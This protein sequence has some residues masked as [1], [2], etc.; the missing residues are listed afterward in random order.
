M[1]SSKNERFKPIVK[2]PKVYT[3]QTITSKNS[4]SNKSIIEDN[5]TNLYE[6]FMS[7]LQ[8]RVK[9][10]QSENRVKEVYLKYTKKRS[11]RDNLDVIVENEPH[12]KS[13][14]KPIEPSRNIK[15]TSTSSNAP[16]ISIK[17]LRQNFIRL[18]E[19]NKVGYLNNNEISS[20]SRDYFKY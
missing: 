20:V 12:N 6:H 3:R 10:L 17:L 16:K 4:V 18:K 14:D 19:E 11:K 15:L 5:N 7:L 1:R 8:R 9:D 13:C 2:T